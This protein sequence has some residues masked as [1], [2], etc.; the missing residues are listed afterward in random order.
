MKPSSSPHCLYFPSLAFREDL[1]FYYELVFYRV[2]HKKNS[3]S[4]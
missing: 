1:S 2:N 3:L 4:L